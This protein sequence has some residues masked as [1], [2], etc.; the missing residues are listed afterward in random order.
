VP[1]LVRNTAVIYKLYAYIWWYFD[2]KVLVIG[3]VDGV[4]KEK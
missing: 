3:E 1:Y 2:E 4:I